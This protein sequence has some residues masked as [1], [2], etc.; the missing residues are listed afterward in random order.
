MV[1]R[2]ATPL[3]LESERSEES[4]ARQR[5]RYRGV[6]M[7]AEAVFVTGTSAAVR[8]S[9]RAGPLRGRGAEQLLGKFP[10]TLRFFATS[11]RPA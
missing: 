5:T 4:P 3:A 2:A 10:I 8:E 1:G 9:G 7:F 6:E 11:P